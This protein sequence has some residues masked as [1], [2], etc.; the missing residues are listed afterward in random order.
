MTTRVFNTDEFDGAEVF[1][2][3]DRLGNEVDELRRIIEEIKELAG[4]PLIEEPDE[5]ISDEGG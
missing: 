1:R 4:I 5:P 3:I 2:E